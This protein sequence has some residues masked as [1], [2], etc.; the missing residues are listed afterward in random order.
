M[1]G[2]GANRN[3][4]RRPST[5]FQLINPNNSHEIDCWS[6]MMCNATIRI[7]VTPPWSCW[8]GNVHKF[9]FLRNQHTIL[10]SLSNFSRKTS[11][12]YSSHFFQ[13]SS[14]KVFKKLPKT[15]SLNQPWL[16]A[17]AKLGT[18]FFGTLRNQDFQSWK[19]CLL[20]SSVHPLKTVEKNHVFPWRTDG[21]TDGL[22]EI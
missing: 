17:N 19:S 10:E 13:K 21:R 9:N 18:S 2:R 20:S 1:H 3:N 11:T 4:S 6:R 15:G 12:L 22:T 5:P 7:I 16:T 8:S 14:P